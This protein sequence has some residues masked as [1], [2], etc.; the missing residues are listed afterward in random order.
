METGYIKLSRKLTN[1]F[2]WL[3]EPFTKAQAWVDILMHAKYRDLSIE[4][5]RG[6]VVHLNRGQF[7]APDAYWEERW[8][9]S[10]NKVRSYFKMLEQEHMI[11][12]EH[13]KTNRRRIIVTVLNYDKY[14]GE[15]IT[16]G[17]SEST[18]EG[19]TEGTSE[20]TSESTSEGTQKK[21]DKKEKNSKEGE[22]KEAISTDNQPLTRASIPQDELDR[23]SRTFDTV[24]KY[25]QSVYS[26][27]RD[28][29]SQMD[30]I[31]A[32]MSTRLKG[33]MTIDYTRT[34]LDE[35]YTRLEG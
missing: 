14:Q 28:Q 13:N 24:D 8:Q 12:R 25:T 29:Y 18:S 22:E 33:G 19:I 27:L 9:W 23:L 1:N 2:L 10:R 20:S 4:L 31:D 15:G 21:K 30:L 32:L 7:F 17:T 16:E 35:E 6:E 5:D 3:S 26:E 11:T 34:I